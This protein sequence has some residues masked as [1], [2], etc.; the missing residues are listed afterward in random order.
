MDDQSDNAGDDIYNSIL[1][2]IGLDSES[3]G[4]AQP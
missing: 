2:E 4:L 1:G 3:V